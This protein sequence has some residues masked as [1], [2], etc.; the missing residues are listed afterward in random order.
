M[1]TTSL[2]KVRHNLVTTINVN[3]RNIGGLDPR[4]GPA[5]LP[6]VLLLEDNQPD[7]FYCCP[8]WFSRHCEG[9]RRLHAHGVLH[10][11]RA[12]SR[13]GAECELCLRYHLEYFPVCCGTRRRTVSS[14]ATSTR[15]GPGLQCLVGACL[16]WQPP[17]D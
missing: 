1:K 7:L 12:T 16:L 2:E 15:K 13:L 11:S 6:R 14:G 10:H 3:T 5:T 8:L 9:S 17:D 4:E